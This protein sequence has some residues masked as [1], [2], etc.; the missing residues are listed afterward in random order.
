MR[1]R[2]ERAF[3]SRRHFL[4]CAAGAGLLGT[5]GVRNLVFI[6]LAGGLSH[7]D[8][9]D[10]EAGPW[11]PASFRPGSFG[12]VQFPTGLM[13]VLTTRLEYVSFLRG[14]RAPSLA[15]PA[16]QAALPSFCSLGACGGESLYGVPCEPA[17]SFE[18]ACA[19]AR[20]RL[21][22]SIGGCQ[23]EITMGGWD[24]HAHLYGTSLDAT[25][26]DSPIQRFDAGVS[27]LLAGLRE[28]GLLGQTLIVAMGEFGRRPGPL[29]SQGGRDHFRTN[30][31]LI[32]G[33]T[34]GNARVLQ[35]G[36]AGGLTEFLQRQFGVKFRL[37]PSAAMAAAATT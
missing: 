37:A 34:A 5:G 11:T 8:T 32:G 4:Q 22:A 6:R 2:H 31:A 33:A 30:A 25:A 7:S 12:D 14:L 26:R 15:H 28:D 24:S 10:F 23:I 1:E 18:D 9:F 19:D 21:C 20:R 13:P 27:G 17:C 16:A 29:N 3:L 36:A 35:A